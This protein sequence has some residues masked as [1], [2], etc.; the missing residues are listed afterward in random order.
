M[1]FD[2]VIINWASLIWLFGLGRL[3]QILQAMFNQ[4]EERV[5]DKIT[6]RPIIKEY[7]EHQGQLYVP[8][9]QLKNNFK[10]LLKGLI[11]VSILVMISFL[12][13]I[14]SLLQLGKLIFYQSI[15]IKPIKLD[16]EL[17]QVYGCCLSLKNKW[18]M[19]VI[20]IFFR[21]RGCYFFDSLVL[22]LSYSF[23]NFQLPFHFLGMST[24]RLSLTFKLM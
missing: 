6:S 14:Y 10:D 21:R 12:L 8:F 13:G 11:V 9:M 18:F 1:G 16:Y 19:G 17:H 20:V 4:Q 5:V 22:I 24:F 3:W 23:L 7:K 15:L 2:I